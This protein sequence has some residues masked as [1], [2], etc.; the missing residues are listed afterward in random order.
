[1]ELTLARA[2][3]GEVGEQVP[4]EIKTGQWLLP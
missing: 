1:V 2:R 4:K 3:L